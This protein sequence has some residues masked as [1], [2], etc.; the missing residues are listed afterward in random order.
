MLVVAFGS[1]GSVRMADVAVGA[2]VGFLFSQVLSAADQKRQG[3][4]IGIGCRRPRRGALLFLC[5][6]YRLPQA[7]AICRNPDALPRVGL[8]IFVET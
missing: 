7:R 3:R 6:R 8:P 4:L 1:A 2:A 5:Y